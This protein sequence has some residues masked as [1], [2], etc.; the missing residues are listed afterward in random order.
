MTHNIFL[1]STFYSHKMI[2]S[3]KELPLKYKHKRKYHKSKIKPVTFN[4]RL[5]TYFTNLKCS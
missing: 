3:S 1:L 4:S 2:Q 5:M